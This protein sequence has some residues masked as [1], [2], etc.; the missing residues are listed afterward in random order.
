MFPNLTPIPHYGVIGIDFRGFQFSHDHSTPVLVNRIFLFPLLQTY[1]QNFW[2]E[3]I[4][5]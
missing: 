5:S 4:Y 1:M 2:M 3:I